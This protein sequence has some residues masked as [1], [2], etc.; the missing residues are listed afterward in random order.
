MENAF[1]ENLVKK[2]RAKSAREMNLNRFISIVNV[3]ISILPA[4]VRI[5][6]TK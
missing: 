4:F 6:R 3:S 1:V 2:E 5:P